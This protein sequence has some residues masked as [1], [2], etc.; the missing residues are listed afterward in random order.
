MTLSSNTNIHV[1]LVTP[2][3]FRSFTPPH[4][5]V[6]DAQTT[7][8]VMLC[9]SAE[10]KEEVD[11]WIETA[12]KAGGKADPNALPQMEGMHGR[13]FE[14]LDGHVWEMVWVDM[15]A[16]EARTACKAEGQQNVCD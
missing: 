10:S 16:A 8:E 13:S 9:L 12:V 15:K 1:M 4:K 7:T 3:K 11:N 5:S 6:A 14:D 2:D